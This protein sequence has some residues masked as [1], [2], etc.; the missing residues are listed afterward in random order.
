M[1]LLEFYIPEWFFVALSLLILV[2]ALTKLLWKP[3][4]KILD[5][6]QEK[7]SK[8]LRDAEEIE[9]GMRGMEER[10]L[11]FERE[12]DRRTAEQMKE[13]RMRAGQEYDRI[14]SEAEEKAR[15]IVTSAQVQAVQEKGA[16][17]RGA[18]AEIVA[19]ALAAAGALI[20]ANM[21]DKR[22]EKLIEAFLA[23]SGERV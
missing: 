9:A 12:L 5:E 6:R 1:N 10:R 20:G 14:I 16:M 21:D 13:A 19:A 7:I 15:A 22:N 17:L 11:E 18:K 23:R 2:F 4:N 8:S 3:V